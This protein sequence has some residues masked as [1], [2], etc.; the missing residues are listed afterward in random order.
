M[1]SAEVEHIELTPKRSLLPRRKRTRIALVLIVLL[2]AAGVSA[3]VTREDIADD[4]I[5]DEL[6]RLDLSATYEIDEIG[7]Q[8]QVLTNLVIGD[9]E[10]PDLIVER[11]VAD[12]EYG[13]GAPQ[14]GRVEL[15]GARL[16]GSYEDGELSFGALDN[17][18]FAEGDAEPDLPALNV[19]L[20]DARALIESDYGAVGVKAAGEGMLDDGFVGTIA[21]TVP[22]LSAQGCKADQATLYGE[23][24]SESGSLA[25]EGP[26]RVRQFVCADMGAR[27]ASADVAAELSLAGDFAS[28]Q[29]KLDIAASQ[30]RAA[31]TEIEALGGEVQLSWRDGMLTARHDVSASNTVSD[32]GAIGSLVADGTLR[33]RDGFERVE[34]DAQIEGDGTS[35][36]SN[37]TEQLRTVR[38]SA[39]GTLIVP[40][41]ERFEAGLGRAASGGSIAADL[42]VRSS[43]EST[44]LVMPQGRLRAAS[45]ETLLGLSRFTWSRS[46]NAPGRLS[47]NIATGGADI[48]R[49]SGRM[50]R[51]DG[52]DLALRFRMEEYVAGASRLAIPELRVTQGAGG[53]LRFEGEVLAS[54]DL[55]GGT[56][57]G[58]N[59]PLRGMWSPSS[60]LAIGQQCTQVRFAQLALYEVSLD[61]R[62]L[63]LCPNGGALVRYD[64]ALQVSGQ[65]AGLALDGDIAGTPLALT[66][67]RVEINYP[68]V[69]TLSGLDVAIGD[70]AEPIRLSAQ[71]L[72]ANFT[73]SIIGTFSGGE[74]RFDF[75]ASDPASVYQI[76]F[77]LL[78]LE[79]MWEYTDRLQIK[80]ASFVLEDRFEEDRF[81]PLVARDAEMQLVGNV[82]TGE[83]DLRHPASDRLVTSVTVNHYLGDGAGNARLNVADLT[84]DGALQ[85]D[86]LTI[87][88]DGV[89]ALANGRVSGNGR[90][91]WNSEDVTSSG[92]FTTDKFDFAAAFGPV[93]DARATIEFTDLL[94]LTTAPDQE[95]SLGSIN[96]GIEVLDGKVK[97][98]LENGQLIKLQDAR[99]PFMGGELIMRGVD[100]NFAVPEERRYI[101]EIVDLDAGTF[102]SEMEFGN[103]AASGTFNGTV[104]IIFD[105]QGNGRIEGGL[106]ISEAP[107]G[108][109]SYVGDLTYEDMGAITNYAFNT[110]RSLDYRQMAVTMDGSLTGE[111]ITSV[112]FDGISQGEGASQNFVT[113]RIAKLPIRFNI[114]VRSQFWELS[115]LLRSTYDAEYLQDPCLTSD[116]KWRASRFYQVACAGKPN[117]NPEDEPM[118][119]LPIQPQESET[120]P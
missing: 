44:S 23:V 55:P 69:A 8:T 28:A 16:F 29:G 21:A 49:I 92:T 24:S 37:L 89:V 88:T 53:A 67:D 1:A 78:A 31:D 6:S 56:V 66:A 18:L 75:A 97:Y 45:G 107:G 52:G 82:I 87:Y 104:P 11:V 60:G 72:D 38:D 58:L 33:A 94:A 111:I 76:P 7:P 22:G 15:Q 64:D 36:G 30:M 68:G 100:L 84:F 95:I 57:Q 9:P 17:V 41:L 46:T 108:N 10:R 26:V 40:L 90:I 59:I 34:W 106:L 54:G 2:A 99:W 48:P 70:P 19:K 110:L 5:S 93:K 91:D 85:P 4:L 117:V 3:W 103:L 35:L 119:E 27:L 98:A 81:Y 109:L 39:T 51:Q 13:F 14:L 83:A 77:E 12:I 114:N 65:I 115:R 32:F 116:P 118:G 112:R 20:V 61:Q 105:A 50:E 74:V 102:I 73:D 62:L 47:G 25:F 96:T 80:G 79:G 86:E 43:P 113:R 101:F 63:T 42:T 120:K 71:S